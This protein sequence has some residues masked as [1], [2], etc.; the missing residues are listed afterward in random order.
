[1]NIYYFADILTVIFEAFMIFI[2][3]ETLFEE[4]SIF[5]KWV[6][7][8][9][10][11]VLSGLLLISNAVFSFNL[12]NAFVMALSVFIISFMYK[13]SAALKLIASVISI[14]FI[15]VIEIIVMFFIT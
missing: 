13:G 8:I 7:I 11:G 15:G 1:M 5:P 9:G 12:L 10:V 2:F 6:Y 14:L 4:R 3:L